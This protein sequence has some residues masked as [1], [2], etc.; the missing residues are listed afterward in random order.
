VNSP[1]F[2]ADGHIAFII[3]RAVDVTQFVKQTLRHEGN[4]VEALTRREQMDAEIFL[5]SKKF[6][7]RRR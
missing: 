1:V 4:P 7:M 5:N 3:T 6:V 2:G